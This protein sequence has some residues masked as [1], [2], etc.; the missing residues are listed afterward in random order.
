[1]SELF[2]NLKGIKHMFTSGTGLIVCMFDECNN[3]IGYII[4][5]F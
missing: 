2:L 1:M 3:L 5:I 4:T